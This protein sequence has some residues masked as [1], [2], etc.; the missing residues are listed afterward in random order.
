MTCVFFA[1]PIR[2]VGIATIS[3]CFVVAGAPDHASDGG[4][5]SPSNVDLGISPFGANAV[6]VSHR[7][8]AA[9]GSG[10]LVAGRVVSMLRGR[11]RS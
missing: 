11:S 7:G 10:G 8:R 3:A 4:A 1:R 9:P 2:C 6:E 5:S